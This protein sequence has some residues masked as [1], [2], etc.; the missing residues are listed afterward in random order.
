MKGKRREDPRPLLKDMRML[1]L[2]AYAHQSKILLGRIDVSRK[3]PCPVRASYRRTEER[4]LFLRGQLRV[5]KIQ[6]FHLK[7]C[8]P[9]SEETGNKSADGG[10]GNQSNI[11][12]HCCPRNLRASPKKKRRPSIKSF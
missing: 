12:A 10:N 7:Q 6:D 9:K 3:L 11:L 4:I 8:I 2:S 1:T 5:H